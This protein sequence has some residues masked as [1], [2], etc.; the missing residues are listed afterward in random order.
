[1]Q[2][3]TSHEMWNFMLVWFGQLISIVGSG[4]TGFALGVW[5][6]QLTGSVTQFAL[7]ALFTTLPS[8]IISPLAG[9][10][11]DRWDRR[12][13]MILSDTG[14][15]LCTLLIAMLLFTGKLTIVPIYILMALIST[16]SAFQW[17]AYSASITLLVPQR[18]LGRANGLVQLGQASAQIIAPVLAG[19]LVTT[20][21]IQGVILIDFISYIFALG[22]LLVVRIPKPAAAP[23]SE[24]QK[25][26]LLREMIYGWTYITE[27]PGLF[28]L[29]IFLAISNFLAC[30][31][32]VLVAPLVLSMAS[33]PMLGTVLSIGGIGMLVGGFVMS[34]WGGGKRRV[35]SVFGFIMLEGLG[36]ALIG[37]RPSITL[38][39]ISAF[40]VF[41]CLPIVN[42][43]NQ[44]IWQSKVVPG[45]QGRVFSVSRM[46]AGATMPAAYLA[47]GPLADRV[48]EPLLAAG[49]PL[50]G[51]V[52]ELVGTGPGR[53]IGL[54]FVVIGLLTML[55]AA[56]SYL[57]PRLRLVE[58]ELPDVAPAVDASVK[59]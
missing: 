26:S 39:I 58:D 50:A 27:R 47:A 57:Y 17:P 11:V 14:A 7:I 16:F 42:G 48:F 23:T 33:A 32:S 34:A 31:V 2:R 28:G 19:I 15:G 29:L 8:L 35:Y 52:G 56:L 40:V 38:I 4:L 6:Y 10:L 43:A 5:V 45:A 9:A 51:S 25:S 53:G 13:A 21:Q 24:T 59:A 46:I 22:M 41:F 18:H 44:A 30:I 37:L 12:W 20:I 54:L 55:T 1:M 36:I 49:G 3:A